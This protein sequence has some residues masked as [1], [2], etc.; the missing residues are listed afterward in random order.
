MSA[1]QFDV[2]SAQQAAALLS[3][4]LGNV[5]NWSDFLS[6]CAREKGNTNHHGLTLEAVL[7]VQD[8]CGR[9][10]YD[11]ARVKAFIFKALERAPRPSRAEDFRPFSVEIDSSYLDL[12][13]RMRRAVRVKERFA[14]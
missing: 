14:S 1:V 9:P 10:V 11:P 8:R 4:A 2:W 12:P 6:D 13:V 7:Y 5:R 3:R